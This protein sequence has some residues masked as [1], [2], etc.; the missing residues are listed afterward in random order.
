LKTFFR[1]PSFYFL[2]VKYW[3]YGFC[4]KNKYLKY[5]RQSSSLTAHWRMEYGV[6]NTYHTLNETTLVF[7]WKKRKSTSENATHFFS[8]P[9]GVAFLCAN[10]KKITRKFTFFVHL[11]YP[12]KLKICSKFWFALLVCFLRSTQ[13]PLKLTKS[14]GSK[15]FS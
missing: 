7:N 1:F 2:F 6:E 3:E 10:K 13:G 5:I 11:K 9:V 4:R 12:N 14:K 8:V 15:F